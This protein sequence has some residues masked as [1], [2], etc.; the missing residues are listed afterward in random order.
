MTTT[1]GIRI[2]AILLSVIC[3]TLPRSAAA[4]PDQELDLALSL[5]TMLQSAR[6]V[7]G[8][9]QALINDPDVGEKNMGGDVVLTQAI[10]RFTATTGA[11]PKET[12]AET[13]A[14]LMQAE[15]DAIVAVMD[16]HQDEID[17]KGVGF[18][19]FVPAVFARLVN[20]R[21]F[22]LAG[23]RAR[24]KVTAPADLVRNRKARPDAWERNIIE[25]QLSQPDWPE[26]GVFHEVTEVDGRSALRVLVPEYYG[27]GCLS[28]H[29]AP[30]GDID[31]TGY[32]KEGGKLGQLGGVI[33]ITLFQ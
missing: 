8:E 25:T 7:I 17:R 24:I 26:G 2:L 12:V 3:A 22:E 11:D 33:S 1:Y 31:V 10:D 27:E 13:E 15:M 20:E 5:A 28:C 30:V 18:K 29:G 19:G 32:P 9:H 23:E 14:W 21:F 4:E 16:A 6:G